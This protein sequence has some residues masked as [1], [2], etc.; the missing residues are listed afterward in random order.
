MDY[1]WL[2]VM[3]LSVVWTLILTAPIHCRGFIAE[4][5]ITKRLQTCSDEERN[6][7]SWHHVSPVA[8]QKWS[9]NNRKRVVL[10]NRFL[11]LCVH[12]LVFPTSVARNVKVGGP[13]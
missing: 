12:L 5:V 2:I 6:F 1:L 13:T 4:Q 3:F 9:L 8:G 11:L 10:Y 7:T